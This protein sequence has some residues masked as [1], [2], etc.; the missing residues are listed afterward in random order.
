MRGISDRRRFL[1]PFPT[2]NRPE[3][4]DPMGYPVER[5]DPIRHGGQDYP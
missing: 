5:L 4:P 3:N 1:F 2:R